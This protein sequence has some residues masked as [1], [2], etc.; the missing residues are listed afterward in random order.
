M[1]PQQLI[2][3]FR[4]TEARVTPHYHPEGKATSLCRSGDSKLQG[5]TSYQ[6]GGGPRITSRRAQNTKSPTVW[7]DTSGDPLRVLK[8]VH[9]LNQTLLHPFRRPRSAFHVVQVVREGASEKSCRE[10]YSHGEA[11]N[12]PA[13]DLVYASPSSKIG[14][15]Q[16]GEWGGS[17]KRPVRSPFL[18]PSGLYNQGI[19]CLLQS[20]PLL[21]LTKENL[22]APPIAFLVPRGK[23]L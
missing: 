17:D 3:R 23:I 5:V 16:S 9:L 8:E 2:S 11:D 19:F 10:G 4:A 6:L 1:L 18:P 21:T 7:T 13:L 14:E 12:K 22:M 15:E 20:P